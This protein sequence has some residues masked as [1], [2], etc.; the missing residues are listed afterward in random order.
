MRLVAPYNM[1]D[2]YPGYCL[3]MSIIQVPLSL[4]PTV[5]TPYMHNTL[6]KVT[7]VI[8]EQYLWQKAYPSL[9]TIN[10]QQA[11]LMLTGICAT[12]L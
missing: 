8:K 2:A 11:K 9:L 7:H 4:C 1:H 6:I 3:T 5:A 10:G 12:M